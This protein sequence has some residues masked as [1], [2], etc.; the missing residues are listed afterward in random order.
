[1]GLKKLLA[2]SAAAAHGPADGVL[3]PDLFYAMLRAFGSVNVTEAGVPM[4]GAYSVDPHTRHV[5]LTI[6]ER[7]ETYHS[8]C[9]FCNDSRG[10]LAVNHRYGTVDRSR[11]PY[12]QLELWKCYNEEC[13]AVEA[14]RTALCIRLD[15][16]VRADGIPMRPGESRKGWTRK[17]RPVAQAQE[18]RKLEPY[19]F[20]GTEVPVSTLPADHVAAVYLDARKFDRDEL[21][22][23]W[24]VTFATDLP[25]NTRE[26][27]SRYRVI[28]PVRV[29]GVTVG[30]QARYPG[31]LNWKTA[32][33]QKYLTYFQKSLALYGA[34]EAAAGPYV[35]V[36]EGPT[37]VWRYGP[38]AVSLLGKKASPTQV[39]LLADLAA[40]RPL[41]FVPDNNDPQSFPK[42]AETATA[43]RRTQI[44]RRLSVSPVCVVEV[45]HG[46]DPAGLSRDQFHVMVGASATSPVWAA[47]DRPE[48]RFGDQQSDR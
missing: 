45:P 47:D 16:D 1:M 2:D 36:V 12:P 46:T 10:R 7:G 24:G 18:P 15:V 32:G 13:Q 23:V 28:I 42:F 19:A 37:D 3:N 14:N 8:D 41:V 22:R 9:P 31:E 38:G 35:V 39:R 30:W 6:H 5:N 26:E 40:G 27:R 29:A 21:Y 33:V 43:V 25:P 4:C 34:D 44:E 48:D 20:P 11:G 17:V